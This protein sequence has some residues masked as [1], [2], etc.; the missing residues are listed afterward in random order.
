MT[1][2]GTY[3]FI[4]LFTTTDWA[5][6]KNL[7]RCFGAPA[8]RVS[9][10]TLIFSFFFLITDWIRVRVLSRLQWN[11]HASMQWISAA[12]MCSLTHWVSA[13]HDL[14]GGASVL[15]E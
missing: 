8:C 1:V 11:L 10:I 15:P 5:T 6:D 2:T 7:C 4:L 3:L 13:Q 9:L 14:V 12:P